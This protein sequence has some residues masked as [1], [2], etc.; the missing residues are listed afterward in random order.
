MLGQVSVLLSQCIQVD[1]LLVD[2]FILRFELFHK[3]VQ[4]FRND[5]FQRWTGNLLTLFLPQLYKHFLE[6]SFEGSDL[7]HWH[8]E[9]CLGLANHGVNL[10]VLV[11]LLFA[12]FELLEG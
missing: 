5:L 1:C 9:L 12:G 3:R 8:V 6:V 4:G 10:P 11:F 2:R 7:D